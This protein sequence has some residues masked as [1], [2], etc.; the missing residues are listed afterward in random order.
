MLRDHARFSYFFSTCQFHLSLS[1]TYTLIVESRPNLKLRKKRI[2]F[3]VIQHLEKKV[4]L[5]HEMS[6]SSTFKGFIVLVVSIYKYI[7]C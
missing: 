7:L 4:T 6:H 2:K 1:Q 5:H 3:I